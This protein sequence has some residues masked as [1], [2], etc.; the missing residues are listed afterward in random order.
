[1][2][3]KQVIKRPVITEKTLKDTGLNKYTFEVDKKATKNQ[4]KEAVELYFD[5]EVTGVNT[6]K[7]A[8]ERRRTGRRRLPGKTADTKK[9]V[10]EVKS[11]QTIK[12]FEVKS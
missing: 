5:V 11:G 4:V 1:M 6:S 10:V 9:A 2:N 7:T 3:L 12:A 8:G